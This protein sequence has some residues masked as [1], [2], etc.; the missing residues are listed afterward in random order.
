MRATSLEVFHNSPREY[1]KT[2]VAKTYQREVVAWAKEIA[3]HIGKVQVAKRLL[4][5][6]SIP[7]CLPV[8]CSQ[9]P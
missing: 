7:N 4:E 6:Q 1:H 8:E 3:D 5:S 9:I 2:Y